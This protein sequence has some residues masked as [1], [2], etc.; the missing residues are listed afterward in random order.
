MSETSKHRA[1]TAQYCEGNG[2]DIGSGGDPVV[3]QAVSIDLPDPY[4]EQ[5]NVIHWRGD[6]LDLPFKDRVCD[7][8]YSSHL[9]EDFF[10]WWAPLR[11]WVRVLKSGGHLVILIPDRERWAAA[12][13][14]GQPPNCSHKHEGQVG[15]LTTYCSH[16]GLHPI[17]DQFALPDDPLDYSICFVGRKI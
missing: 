11:E 9:L 1:L 7:F 14:R 10:D 17:L 12:L 13:E 15:E 6:A 3:A 8:V 4:S 2:I 16:L 5:G